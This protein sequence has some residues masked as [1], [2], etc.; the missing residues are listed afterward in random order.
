MSRI[1]FKRAHHSEEKKV[2]ALREG[3]T[4]EKIRDNLI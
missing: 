4:Q 3:S 2:I 1:S